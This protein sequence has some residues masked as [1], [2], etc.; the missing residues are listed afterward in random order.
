MAEISNAGRVMIAVELM[1]PGEAARVLTKAMDRVAKRIG[2][3]EHAQAVMGGMV[4]E[5]ML[6]WLNAYPNA[7]F[8]EAPMVDGSGAILLHA[9][10]ARPGKRTATRCGRARW[11]RSAPFAG[12][13]RTAPPPC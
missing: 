12:C 9:G 2:G 10:A 4:G 8:V 6:G 3:D 13:W 5:V 1:E 7:A 11:R